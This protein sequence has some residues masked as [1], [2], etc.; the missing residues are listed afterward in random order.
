MPVL[1]LMNHNLKGTS[2]SHIFSALLGFRLRDLYGVGIE[3]FLIHHGKETRQLSHKSFKFP[4]TVEFILV[5]HHTQKP[6]LKLLINVIELLSNDFI[7]NTLHN[8]IM[9]F[10]FFRK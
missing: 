10:Q 5:E 7:W 9:Y 2:C 6:F 1:F 8:M 4:D 3:I